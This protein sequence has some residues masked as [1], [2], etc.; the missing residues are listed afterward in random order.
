LTGRDDLD[1]RL[2]EEIRFHL[3][4]QIEKNLRAGMSP[5]EARRA[6]RL[7][8]GGVESAREYTRDEFRWAGAYD[9]ARDAR[10][11]VRM[12]RRSRGAA[13]VA[14]LTMAIGIGANTAMFSLVSAL[15]LHPLPYP[16]TDRLVSVWDS[17]EKNP[18]NEVAFA[19][20]AD[21]K[22][23][24]TSFES[25]GLYRWWT[26]NITGGPEPERV[27]GY[28]LTAEVLQAL[29]LKPQ[30]GRWFTAE[31]NQP[32]RNYVALL[33]DGLW[34]RR[35]GADPNVLGAT[36]M[37]NGVARRIIG[38]MPRELNYP[39]GA[40]VLA[41]LM[42]TPELSASRQAH[43]YYVVGRLKS[44]TSVDAANRELATITADL[45]REY[46]NTNR[47]LGA[48]VF[49]LAEDVSQ[50]YRNGVWLLMA[51]VGF[52][53]LIACA[54]L[55]NV[56]LA[57]A[58]ARAR[59]IA[60][61]TAMGAGRGRIARQILAE[62]L[63]LA[64]VGGA[65]GAGLAALTVQA[66]RNAAPGDLLVSVPGLADL[67]VDVPVLL[68]ALALSVGAG[69]VFGLVPAFG[70]SRFDL[71]TSLRETARPLGAARGHG[72]RHSLVAVEVALALTL[73]SGA[74]FTMKAFSRLAS[75]ET[76]F[77]ST[78]VLTM[79]ITLPYARYPD[80]AAEARFFSN[81]LER[82]ANTPGVIRAGLTSHIPLAPGNA[83]DTLVFEGR[84]DTEPR[85]EA[86]YRAISAGYFETLGARMTRGRAF[87]TTDI[88]ESPRVMIVNEAF[89]RRF[90]P[91]AKAVGRRVRLS[92]PP[93]ANP[94]REIVG[95]VADFRHDL[96]RAPRPETYIPYTQ[97][98]NDT[99]F[100]V[101]KTR[102]DALGVAPALRA[103]VL[104]I[105]PT[106]PVWDVRTLDDIKD[107]AMAAFRALAAFIS[108]FGAIALLLSALGIFGV[109]SFVVSTRTPEIGLRMALGASASGVVSLVMGHALRPLVVG[110]ALGGLGSLA[111]GR[112]LTGAF[113]EMADA[114]TSA[115]FATT[116]VLA[117]V[118]GL[119]TWLPARHAASIAPTEALRSE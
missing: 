38:V 50:S 86:D 67:R 22:T 100:L 8:F 70:A 65:L 107:R 14:V 95:V 21:W 34:R 84:L 54:N 114:D 47:G 75:M 6:A 73:M 18:R 113:P 25:L 53:L 45:A 5:H 98:T 61:R 62:S 43:T 51:S 79:G 102:G 94:W 10:I 36:V 35:F 44:G 26:V 69:V 15:L 103:A 3:D 89:V 66:I 87:A 48:R 71:G 118:A 9:F 29:A 40:E 109:V 63:V 82:A 24:Q 78:N 92:G 30:I 27:Q 52:V 57:R 93:E 68:F 56:L 83:S 33:S 115:A 16:D 39:E 112:L 13:L 105:D 32:G 31:E 1:R 80:S 104:A 76:G 17:S 64:L 28:Q 74:G 101:T 58:P 12:W 110:F 23:R 119:A 46:P 49:P 7:K 72:L 91:D 60:V 59:E 2:D 11:A 108:V 81:L 90:L 99:L 116:A 37:F 55:A 41:P 42:V 20:F 96:N 88:A 77:D 106:E 97:D 85:P 117:I 19:N 4:Q 111:V